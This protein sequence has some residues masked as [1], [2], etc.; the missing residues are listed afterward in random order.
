MVHGAFCGSWVFDAWRT[1]F[2]AKGF[3]V[4]TPLLRHHEPGADKAALG[5]TGLSD[6]VSDL[7]T[8]VE[9]I[10]GS[11]VVIGHSLG[12]LLAQMLAARA[13]V[14]ALVL[15]APSPPWGMFCSTGFEFLSAQALYFEG[16]FWR[17]AIAPRRRLAAEHAIDLVAE[18]RRAAILDRLVPESGQAMFEVLHWMFDLHRAAYVDAR[19][20]SCPI[21][22][23]AGAQ[24]RI[25]PPETVRRIARR[26]GGRARY[27]ELPGHGH[28]LVGEPGSEKIAAGALEWLLR[29]L[30]RDPESVGLR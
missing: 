28:W 18:E 19:A 2:A 4:H 29:V 15:L 14:R 3:A 7:C 12:G 11:P 27:E 9:R 22:C 23:L 25:N 21:L 1:M 26:Y 30:G 8:L 10:D 24:D 16:A 13:Q 17:K 6:Y 5:R 20:V